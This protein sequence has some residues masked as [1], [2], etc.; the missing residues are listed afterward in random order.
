MGKNPN[1]KVIEEVTKEENVIEETKKVEVKIKDPMVRYK[2]IS[3]G[4]LHVQI[5]ECN[6]DKI[7][8]NGDVIII[9]EKY[10]TKILRIPGLKK[11]K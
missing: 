8:L 6:L 5:P 7:A 11:I 4:K 1:D 9:P 3:G 2:N 10:E